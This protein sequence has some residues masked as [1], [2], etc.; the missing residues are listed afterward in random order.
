MNLTTHWV[1]AVAIGVGVFHNVQVALV[2]SV[3]ALIPDLDREYLF[4]AKSFIGRHQLHRSLFHNFF[5]VGALYVLN[6]FLALG[7][8]T[9]SALDMLTRRPTEASSCCSR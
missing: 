6:P 1:L 8:L 7:A 9:H 4:V 3:G 2:M 5:L